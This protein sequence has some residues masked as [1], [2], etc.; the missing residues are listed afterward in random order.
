MRESDVFEE[1]RRALKESSNELMNVLSEGK[2]R[3]HEEYKWVTGRL[4]GI[5]EALSEVDRVEEKF[6]AE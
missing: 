3:N 6:L 1:I 2:C 5:R 4:F